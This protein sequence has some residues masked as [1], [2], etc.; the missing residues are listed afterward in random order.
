MSSSIDYTQVPPCSGLVGRI[1]GHRFQERSDST[2]TVTPEVAALEHTRTYPPI[3]NPILPSMDL[4]GVTDSVSRVAST[5]D[6]H[7]YDICA[8]CGLTATRVECYQDEDADGGA[9]A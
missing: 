9:R 6:Y 2:T 3:G 7:H 1:F 8:R 4:M 5:D